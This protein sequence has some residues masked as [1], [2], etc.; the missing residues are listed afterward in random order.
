MPAPINLEGRYITAVVLFFILTGA[1]HMSVLFSNPY[2]GGC[3]HYLTP[4]S[5]TLQAN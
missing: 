2:P 3:T 5:A 4:R 1:D